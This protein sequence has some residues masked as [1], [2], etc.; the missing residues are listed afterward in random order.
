MKL[1][2]HKKGIPTNI[3]KRAV[4]LI[5]V[6]IVSVVLFEIVT[7]VTDSVEITVQENPTLPVL[8][9]NFLDD[10]SCQLH[11]YVTE[12]D[13][14]YMRDAVIPLDNERNIDISLNAGDFPVDGLSYELRSLDTQRN[15]SNNELDFDN[16]DGL[17]TAH[18]KAENLIDKNE[19]YLLIITL[20]SDEKVIY[21]YTRIMQPDGC[22]EGE[23]LDFAQYFHTN[24]LS[25]DAK[26]LEELATFIEP[27]PYST[28]TDLNHVT[29]NSSL[30]NIGYGNFNG[31]QIGDCNVALTDITTNYTSL[32]LTY[33]LALD[34][35]GRQEYYLCSEDFR[36]RSGAERIYLLSYDRTMEQLLDANSIFVKGNKVNI[37][38]TDQNVKYLSNET[39]TI[40]SFIQNGSLY[41]YNQTDRKIKQIFSFVDDPTDIRSIY[42]QH[43]ILLLNIDESGTMDYVVYGYMNSGP[44]EGQCGINLFHYDAISDMSSEQ[45]FIATTSSYQILNAN[46][47]KLLYETADNELYTMVNG[48]LLYMS[49]ND[50][51]T[52][53]IMTGLDDDQFAVSGSRRY[54]S[55]MDEKTV[56]D[57]IHIMDLETGDSFDIKADSGQLLKP[58]A[59]AED[60]LIFGTLNK[61]DIT[62]DGAGATIY[63]MN[64]LTIADIKSGTAHELMSYQ[65]PGCFITDIT[66]DSYTI[67]L[68][69]IQIDGEGNIFPVEEDSIKNTA[70]A[71]NKAV[72][73]TTYD[74]ETKQQCVI[75]NMT[76]LAED[77]SLG[78]VSYN[79]S[80]MVL[81]DASRSVQVASSSSSTQYFVYAGNQVTLATDDL[82]AAIAEADA[83][84][85]IVIDNTP[86]Y[87]WKRGRKAY[88]G[89]IES[90]AVG[91]SDSD[92]I[93]TARALSAMLVHEGENV[94]VHTLIESG[95]TPIS[96]LS[97][98]LK[99]YDILDLTGASLTQVL[100]YVS[101][102]TPV[103][104]YTGQDSAVLITGYDATTITYFDPMN[105]K[106]SKM[107]ISE[108]EEYFGSVGN[109]FVSYIH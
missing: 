11:G 105:N 60:D 70:G 65:K 69:L 61:N 87:V 91:S 21:Y 106:L 56:A 99:G 79:I 27:D 22:N 47:S 53:E 41:Q 34:R 62:E 14:V 30:T 46:F 52:K 84:M 80:D 40:V 10:A 63:P 94:Q 12:M 35:D 93:G 48:T 51:T 43:K 4:L 68:N 24:A 96:I 58:M 20:K 55:W 50:L 82:I 45:V 74:D 67:Y 81:A 98:T 32:T 13:P 100:Y 17:V 29:I 19:E 109:V 1:Q 66:L 44:H 23:I 89:S 5:A 75:L 26:A 39:G 104:A 72:P 64:K 42:N 103:Y 97:R 108:A 18:F 33:E 7:N 54:L 85:G 37:G 36:I 101:Q 71:Q 59:F 73:I 25:G 107:G 95:D 90:I 77:E 2:F 83:N 78:V 3:I 15:I 102:G 86:K 88:Q 8:N 6:F 28:N 76:E 31:K 92:A 49:L 38:I 57:K 9:V 16:K